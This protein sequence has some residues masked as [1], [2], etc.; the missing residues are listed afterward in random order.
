VPVRLVRVLAVMLGLL[1]IG[2]APAGAGDHQLELVPEVNAFFKLSDRLRLFFLGALTQG[3]TESVTA[4]EAGAYLD[5]T[6]VPILRRRLREGD[7]EREHYLWIRL[8]HNV[9]GPLD[10]RDGGV[11]HRGVLEGTARAPLPQD[12]WLV[13]RVRVDLRDLD[14]EFSARLRYRLGIERTF[15]VGN[16]AL[17]PYAQAEVFYDTRF[18]TFN[19]QL[20]QGGVEVEL[21]KHWRIEPYYAR[22]EDQRSSPGHVDRVGLVLKL[23]W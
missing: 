23:Y 6:L 8:G 19:R 1:A 3:P 4:A 18:G 2:A 5:I 12:L 20:Y 15:A 22:Q 13:N 9:S 14:G 21:T 16:F 7:W 11:E 10:G 17:T